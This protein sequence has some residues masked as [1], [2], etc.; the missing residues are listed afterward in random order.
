MRPTKP[1]HFFGRKHPHS[2][3]DSLGISGERDAAMRRIASLCQ[4]H[5]GTD[6]LLL[7]VTGPAGNEGASLISAGLATSFAVQTGKNVVHIDA[8]IWARNREACPA[9]LSNWIAEGGD[10]ARFF[11]TN[12]DHAYKTL[13]VGNAQVPMV[14]SAW[15]SFPEAIKSAA[16]IVVCDLPSPLACPESLLLA[17]RLDG[18]VLVVEAEETRWQVAQTAQ[19]LM[20]SAQVQIIGVVLNKRQHFIPNSI[21]RLL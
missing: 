16:D 14:T 2:N 11:Q 13:P 15:E 17:A 1:W 8:H 21:Y 9:G 20:E 5:I 12:D 4:Q 3:Q 10:I 18:V 19:R 6:R 7:G